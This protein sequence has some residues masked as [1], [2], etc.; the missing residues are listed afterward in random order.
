M[1]HR[2]LDQPN[3]DDAIVL[4]PGDTLEIRLRQ[5]G[6]TGYLWSIAQASDLLRMSDDRTELGSPAAGAAA[7][8]VLMFETAESGEEV[9][10]LE[11]GRQW[12]QAPIEVIDLP[13]TV[14]AG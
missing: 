6:G 14:R 11:L 10:H 8:R 4:V 13:V 7:T 9:L 1:T 12:E 3:S 2:V 5:R